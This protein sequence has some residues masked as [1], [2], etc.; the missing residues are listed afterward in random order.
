MTAYTAASIH[1]ASDAEI[2]G[3]WDWAR[4]GHWVQ[5]YG[6]HPDWLARAVEACRRAGREP[7]YIERRYLQ[8]LRDEEPHDPAVDAAL[9]EVQEEERLKSYYADQRAVERANRGKT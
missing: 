3:A 5:V 4:V 1:I 8:G 9:R 6:C 7:E 2:I